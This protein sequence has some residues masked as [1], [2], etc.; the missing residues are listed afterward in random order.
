MNPDSARRAPVQGGSKPKDKYFRYE[1]SGHDYWSDLLRLPLEKDRAQCDAWR[2][3]VQNI[4]IFVSLF[5]IIV[6]AFVIESYKALALRQ[7]PADTTVTLLTHI[8]ARLDDPSTPLLD[9]EVTFTPTSSSV[10]VNAFWVI[11]LVLGLTSAL[12]GILSL[13]WLCED[14]RYLEH[15]LS[16]WKFVFLNMR[17]E[18]IDRWRVPAF[19]TALSVLLQ[20]AFVLFFI[21][22]VD[23]FAR[24]WG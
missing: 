24:H 21:G 23:F 5:S 13:Q 2:D 3:E 6:T 12:I 1:R 8:A 11:S 14:Q 10:R 22:L 7:D 19:F 16:E 20:L 15:F 18:M 9:P 17:T 4:L